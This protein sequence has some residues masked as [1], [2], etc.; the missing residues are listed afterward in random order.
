M[1]AKKLETLNYRLPAPKSIRWVLRLQCFVRRELSQQKTRVTTPIAS[2]GRICL[3][4]SQVESVHSLLSL[5]C[6]S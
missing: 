2:N 6:L 1:D 3:A 4:K 5:S